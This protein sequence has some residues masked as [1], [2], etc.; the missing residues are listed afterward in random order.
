MIDATIHLRGQPSD[1]RQLPAVP[2]VGSYIYGNV[3]WQV[4]AVVF[5]SD[6]VDVYTIQVSPMLAAELTSAWAAWG[7]SLTCNQGP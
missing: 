5:G 4:A 6:G 7:E 3:L 2:V 1:Q